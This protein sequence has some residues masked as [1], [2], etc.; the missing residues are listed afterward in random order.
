MFFCNRQL[1]SAQSHIT[2]T[3]S[4]YSCSNET[5]SGHSAEILHQ[6]RRPLAK[7]VAQTYSPPPLTAKR[8]D[9]E[10]AGRHSPLTED[11]CIHCFGIPT[12]QDTGFAKSYS[13]H[14]QAAGGRC[15]ANSSLRICPSVCARC[16]SPH[17]CVSLLSSTRTVQKT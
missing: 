13:W 3:S 7:P 11:T 5:H 15:K 10:T 17:L 6:H 12:S 8:P 16:N 4:S 9:S 1:S 2:S 14:R